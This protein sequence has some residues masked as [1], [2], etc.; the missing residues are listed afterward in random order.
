M[1]AHYDKSFDPRA[2]DEKARADLKR[3]TELGMAPQESPDEIV[4][5]VT[6]ATFGEH[7]SAAEETPPADRED[8]DDPLPNVP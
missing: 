3:N 5:S 7:S 1:R 4:P 8:R 6:P 2:E